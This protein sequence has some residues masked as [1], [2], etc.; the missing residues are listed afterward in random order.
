MS[1][2]PAQTFQISSSHEIHVRI[3]SVDKNNLVFE[4]RI[5]S[6]GSLLKEM[7]RQ[8]LREHPL[9]DLAMER[10]FSHQSF[11]DNL[12]HLA[13]EKNKTVFPVYCQLLT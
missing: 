10:P 12:R 3:F 4:A 9:L 1:F 5:S 2:E 6:L 7:M 8:A 13:T 11:S